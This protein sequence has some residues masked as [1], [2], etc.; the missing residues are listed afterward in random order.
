MVSLL[1]LRVLT[2]SNQVTH[3]PSIGRQMQLQ[4]PKARESLLSPSMRRSPSKASLTQSETTT[5]IA[6]TSSSSTSLPSSLNV[7]KETPGLPSSPSTAE[8]PLSP[9]PHITAANAA[10]LERPAFAIDDAKDED[11]DDGEEDGNFGIGGDDDVMDE[12]DA[13]LE[14]HDSGLSAADQELAKGEVSLFYEQFQLWRFLTYIV[15]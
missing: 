5:S 6:A 13:F 12:V 10:L 14:A 3:K 1:F 2:I 8:P 15:I 9:L 4:E 11:D 7:N